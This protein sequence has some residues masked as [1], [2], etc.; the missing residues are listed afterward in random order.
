[1]K[2]M[3]SLTSSLLKSL[4]YTS[5]SLGENLARTLLSQSHG[6]GV[7]SVLESKQESRSQDTL[8]DLWPDTCQ[9][10]SVIPSS[11]GFPRPHTTVETLPSTLSNNPAH[12]RGHA[13]LASLLACNMHPRFNR[14]IWVSDA[15][16]EEL[17]ERTQKESDERADTLLLLPLNHILQLLEDGVLQN[18]VDDQHQRWHHTGEQSSWALLSHQRQERINSGWCH[19]CRRAWEGGLRRRALASSHSCVDYPDWVGEEDRGRSSYGA[20]H[21]RLD[22]GELCGAAGLACSGLEGAA[23]PFVP[24]VIDEVGYADAE[25]GAVKAG[26]E[27]GCTLALDD[28]FNCLEK[29][30]LGALGLD[31]GAG[32]QGDERIARESSV[33]LNWLEWRGDR[34]HLREKAKKG[35]K[36]TSKP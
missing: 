11:S 2:S 3:T 1:M 5:L 13:L 8:R 25:E 27:G 36:H 29:C 7:Q 6:L 19:W 21:D 22:C 26:V 31:L 34:V 35:A 16:G 14:D 23:R 32:G 20:S 33:W 10:V 18:W 28:R 12:A 9:P 24:V 17:P 15:G 30:G 4:S